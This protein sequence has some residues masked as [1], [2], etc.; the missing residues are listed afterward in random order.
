MTQ[1][2]TW[3][4]KSAWG[5]GPWTEEPD[6]V[7]WYFRD[8]ACL[9][10]R[11]PDSGH[12]C[13][14]AAVHPGHPWHGRDFMD[15]DLDVHGGLT[16]SAP[17]APP[18][19]ERAKR[20][21]VCHVPRPGEPDAVWWLGFDCSHAWDIAPARAARHRE[22][23]P[24]PDEVYRRIGYVKMQAQALAHQILGAAS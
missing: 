13:G 19:D 4:D 24:G 18:S 23:A 10:L 3:I 5:V 22:F 21:Q 15:L 9:A 7:E 1:T 2:E 17:C 16:F 11:H 14:Y 6:R 8:I 20:E 12:W